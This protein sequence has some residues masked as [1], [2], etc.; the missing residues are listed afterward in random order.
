V[1]TFREEPG[2]FSTLL[3]T[4]ETGLTQNWANLES[5]RRSMIL[6][7]EQVMPRINTAIEDRASTQKSLG[8]E[9]LHPV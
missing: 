6:T 8:G 3:Y 7:T 2:D 1:L 5:S 4:A 9:Y